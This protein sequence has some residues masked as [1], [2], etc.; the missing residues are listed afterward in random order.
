MY[1]HI[2]TCVLQHEPHILSSCSCVIGHGL[3]TALEGKLFQLPQQSLLV[4][5]VSRYDLLQTKLHLLNNEKH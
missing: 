5:R 2:C 3:G 4:L 1:M